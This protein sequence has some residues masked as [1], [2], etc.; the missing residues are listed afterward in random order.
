MHVVAGPAE[1]SLAFSTMQ[2]PMI[3]TKIRELGKVQRRARATRENSGSR[4]GEAAAVN[5]ELRRLLHA[6][7][8]DDTGGSVPMRVRPVDL[9]KAGMRRALIRCSTCGARDEEIFVALKRTYPESYAPV[10]HEA[11]KLMCLDCLARKAAEQGVTKTPAAVTAFADATLMGSVQCVSL[12][13][14]MPTEMSSFM[15]TVY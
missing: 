2:N 14:G 9:G 3:A 4:V 6:D 11:V 1:R 10:P 7:V 5:A 13:M 8:T 12:L 15:P